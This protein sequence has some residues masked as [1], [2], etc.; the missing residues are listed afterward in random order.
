[1]ASGPR[2]GN[3]RKHIGYYFTEAEADEALNSYIEKI[4][5]LNWGQ[6][7]KCNKWR[8]LICPLA[9]DV[10]FKCS[11]SSRRCQ[12]KEDTEDTEDT[13]YLQQKQL[14][15]KKKKRKRKAVTTTT[16]EV[17]EV[18]INKEQNDSR[19][20]ETI[21]TVAECRKLWHCKSKQERIALR[22]WRLQ[23]LTD[24][25]KN[26]VRRALL[27]R[28]TVEI[29]TSKSERKREQQKLKRYNELE[30]QRKKMKEELDR[31]IRK[32]Q[33]LKH[34]VLAT[35][36]KNM[37]EED[38]VRI[39]EEKKEEQEKEEEEEELPKTH[40]RHDVQRHGTHIR[41]A[42]MLFERSVQNSEKEAKHLT[43]FLI[44]FF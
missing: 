42:Q 24:S 13:R 5:L 11:D 12:E 39:Q 3:S 1:M 17:N 33:K 21:Q 31:S 30:T 8:K 4:N 44:F 10:P 14:L 2:V 18:P 41:R 25:Q 43:S 38:I 23:S 22:R 37:K 29:K 19:S 26:A 34:N 27:S 7:D 36:K 35:Q 16:A 20:A 9:E 6:C 40:S 28:I 32:R 15:N